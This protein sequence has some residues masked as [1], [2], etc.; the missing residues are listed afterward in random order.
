MAAGVPVVAVARPEVSEFI[1]EGEKTVTVPSTA[2][3]ARTLA[4]RVQELRA[5]R[6]AGDTAAPPREHALGAFSADEFARRMRWLY[7]QV[8]A[9]RGT[10]LPPSERKMPRTSYSARAR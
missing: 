6:D 1:A 7:Q 2:A 10:N 3:S 9:R 4:Q 5:H 8:A